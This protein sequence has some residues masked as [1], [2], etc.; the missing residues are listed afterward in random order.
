M[1]EQIL[2]Y[3]STE[4]HIHQHIASLSYQ[5]LKYHIQWKKKNHSFHEVKRHYQDIFHPQ[6]KEHTI[7]YNQRQKPTSLKNKPPSQIL[8]YSHRNYPYSN[9]LSHNP[10][11]KLSTILCI[12]LS[13]M[14]M[15]HC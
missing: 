9:I 8:P 15:H 11:K 10:V 4:I 5:K 3:Y 13:L 7:L 6:Y 14:E 2:N 1:M 12:F